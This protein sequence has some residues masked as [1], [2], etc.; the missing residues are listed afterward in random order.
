MIMM[1]MMMTETHDVDATGAVWRRRNLDY[2]RRAG[3]AGWINPNIP[4]LLTA[5]LLSG[6]GRPVWLLFKITPLKFARCQ[7]QLFLF[8]RRSLLSESSRLSFVLLDTKRVLEQGPV[9]PP[10]I[11]LPLTLIGD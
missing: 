4:K 7:V 8:P 3:G 10:Q 11:N 1:M 6:L 5:A 9:F 2:R